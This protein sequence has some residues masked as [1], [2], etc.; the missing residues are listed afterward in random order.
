MAEEVYDIQV[1]EIGQRP[2]LYLRDSSG[3]RF[4][5]V[6]NIVSIVPNVRLGGSMVFINGSEKAIT[7][8]QEPHEILEALA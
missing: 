1:V 2:F 4:I 8:E 5:C 6:N 3:A 7:V